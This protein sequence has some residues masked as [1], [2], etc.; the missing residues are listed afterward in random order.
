MNRSMNT[1][2][3]STG[4][5]QLTRRAVV[6]ALAVTALGA[7]AILRNRY[8]LFAQDPAQYSARAIRRI[9]A[10]HALR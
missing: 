9:D 2:H 1:T 7:P 3:V 6:R 4:P 5:R 10:V 8:G